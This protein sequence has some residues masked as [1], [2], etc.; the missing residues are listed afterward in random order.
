MNTD[1]LDELLKA[2]AKQPLPPSSA[3]STAGVWREIEQRRR[4]GAW[5][6]RFFP[7]LGWREMFAESRLAIASVAVAVLTGLLPIAA[8]RSAEAPRLARNS[9]HLD[10]FSTRPSGVPATLLADARMR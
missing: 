5:W 8:A 1:P 6:S 4:R 7:V 9:L 3:A 2:Y 10:V